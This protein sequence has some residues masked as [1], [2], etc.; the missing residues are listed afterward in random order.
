[1]APQTAR[2]LGFERPV[3]G[4]ADPREELR[5]GSSET[6]WSSDPPTPTGAAAWPAVP[7]RFRQ[8]I[9]PVQNLGSP[10][11]RLSAPL[12]AVVEES[13]G[14]YVAMSYDLELAEQGDTEFEALA[15]LREAIVELHD[16]LDE[17]GPE[18]PAH[19]AEKLAFL[20]SLSLPCR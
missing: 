20:R 17:M 13:D 15:R 1:M 6:T 4:G 5:M 9:V 16:T 7:S 3:T 19:L 2:I 12:Y 14:F 10:K 18:A 8:R 11:L